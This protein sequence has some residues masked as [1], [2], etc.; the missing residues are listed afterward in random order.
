MKGTASVDLSKAPQVEVPINPAPVD[1][2]ASMP[3]GRVAATA[4]R[5]PHGEFA[6]D[7]HPTI[8]GGHLTSGA[9]FHHVVFRKL[10]VSV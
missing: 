6:D 3:A 2:M 7:S 4:N 8:S 10:E 5:C 1:R 9:G